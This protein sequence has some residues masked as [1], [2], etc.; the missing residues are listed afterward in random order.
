MASIGELFISLGFEVDEKQLKA[1]D[2]GVKELKDDFFD[3]TAGSIAA[4]YS[5]DKFIEKTT[6]G[7]VALTDF[8]KQTG[9]SIQ[10]TQQW[11]KAAHLADPNFPI[12]AAINSLANFKKNLTAIQT[13]PGGGNALPFGWFNLN[14][15]RNANGSLRS[16]YEVLDELHKEVV[17]RRENRTMTP[18]ME[19]ALIS[20]SGLAPNFIN[21]LGASD[22]KYKEFMEKGRSYSQTD[23][24]IEKLNQLATS[25]EELKMKWESFVISFTA[26]HSEEFSK[27]IG[28]LDKILDH[29]VTDIKFIV[30]NK[31]IFKWI[32][33]ALGVIVAP[34][35]MA[36][37]ATA[38]GIDALA[39]RKPDK[40]GSFEDK[41]NDLKV[42]KRDVYDS[43][44]T[45]PPTVEQ[46]NIINIHGATDPH[47]TAQQVSM[48]LQN[49]F[50]QAYIQNFSA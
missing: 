10:L 40:E 24:Q 2:K 7:A 21:I 3:V 25:F 1:F 13:L 34:E 36:V 23:N 44:L 6:Q 31:D 11:S 4:L 28:G 38:Y 22:A 5:F 29:L 46:N 16:E 27:A 39:N 48:I 9:E 14:V 37:G 49:H 30:D 41:V 33:A 43:P 26:D 19:T 50:N 32:G 42:I 8:N 35:L 47:A 20:Q 17:K 45:N 12:E 18:A 15:M